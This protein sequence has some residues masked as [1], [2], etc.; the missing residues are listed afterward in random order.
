MKQPCCEPP[1][2]LGPGYRPDLSVFGFAD[3]LEYAILAWMMELRQ[4]GVP[5][6]V[7]TEGRLFWVR[8]SLWFNRGPD[9]KRAPGRTE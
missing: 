1:V 6:G 5:N 4:N 7:Y 8:P 3:A 9:I 2:D